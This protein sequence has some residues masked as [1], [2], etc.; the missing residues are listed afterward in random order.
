M[1]S[2][3]GYITSLFINHIKKTQKPDQVNIEKQREKTETYVLDWRDMETR[4]VKF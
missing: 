2:D 4:R 1:S 3:F